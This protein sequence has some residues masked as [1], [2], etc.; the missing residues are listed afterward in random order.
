MC[1]GGGLTF[2]APSTN[3]I[4]W[5]V[6]KSDR[7]R[8]LLWWCWSLFQVWNGAKLT[9]LHTKWILELPLYILFS[10]LSPLSSLLCF[11][12]FPFFPFPPFSVLSLSPLSLPSLSPLSPHTLLSSQ[13]FTRAWSLYVRFWVIRT[14]EDEN[15]HLEIVS[16]QWGLRTNVPCNA[17]AYWRSHS[18]GYSEA[19]GSTD[20][21][22]RRGWYTQKKRRGVR[23]TF[24]L[25]GKSGHES[26]REHSDS[27]TEKAG[28]RPRGKLSLG[29]SRSGKGRN[30]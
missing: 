29:L 25:Q 7:W 5:R 6:E 3:K 18:K 4:D 11:P 16:I 19:E 21:A 8:L 15:C 13:P 2:S 10:L 24:T 28:S 1:V 17:P 27:R 22:I 26:S 12:F 23:A 9:I 20:E 14:I 30:I